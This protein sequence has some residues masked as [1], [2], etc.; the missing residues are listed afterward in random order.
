VFTAINICFVG[1]FL[2][3]ALPICMTFATEV[4]YP[5]QASLSNGICQFASAAGS[6]ILSFVGAIMLSSD[7]SQGVSSETIAK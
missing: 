6:S 2:L 7:V 1:F 5:M 3:P 4:T